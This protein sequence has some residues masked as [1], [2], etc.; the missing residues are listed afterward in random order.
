MNQYLRPT[1]RG[2]YALGSACGNCERCTEQ[3]QRMSMSDMV[4]ASKSNPALKAL[5]EVMQIAVPGLKM[6]H[7]T[8][9]ATI[10]R[11]LNKRGVDLCERGPEEAPSPEQ[12]K[13][14]AVFTA[15]RHADKQ[16]DGANPESNGMTRNEWVG[17]QVITALY[18]NTH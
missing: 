5:A 4:I 13:K 9:A 7:A 16:Y 14:D 1:C 6:P 12:I 18:A 3:R 15:A 11:M 10:E 2:S 17:K 8:L